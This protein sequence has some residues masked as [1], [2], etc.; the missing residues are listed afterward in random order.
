MPGR[1]GVT[2]AQGFGSLLRQYRQRA[3]LTQEELAARTGISTRTIRRL[4]ADQLRRPRSAT[5]RALADQLG[6]DPAE[7]ATLMK[8]PQPRPAGAIPAQLPMDAYGFTGRQAH[9][10]TLDA[11]VTTVDEQPTALLI[12]AIGGTAGIGKTALAV[13]W[14]HRVASRFPDG[15]LYV[16]MRAFAPTGVPVAPH[17]AVRGFLE[18]LGVPPA[19]IP[20]GPDAQVALYRSRLAGRRVL[21]VLDNVRDAD[22]V[23]PL[24][25]GA[26]GCA[27][28]VTSRYQ[29]TSLVAAEGAHPVDLD[30]LS[31]DEA[32]R[33]L[34]RRIGPVRAAAE[35]EAVDALVA[36]CC[37]LP[38]ALTIVAA[39]AVIQPGL[40]LAA[41]AVEL[42]G[43]RDDGLDALTAGD[44]TTD[45][46]AV[47]SWSY[48]AVPPAAGRLFRLLGLHRAPDL[49]VDAA[50]ALAGREPAEVRPLLTELARAHLVSEH[51]PG[52]FTFHDL[53]R[54]YAGELARRADLEDERRAAGHRLLDHYLHTAVATGR[55]LA[56]GDAEGALA[57]FATEHAALLA[58]VDQAAASGRDAQTVELAQALYSFLELRGHWHDLI[59]VQQAAV[60]AARRLGDPALESRA[61][62]NVAAAGIRLG[63]YDEARSHLREAIELAARAGDVG[64]E[65]GARYNLAFLLDAQRDYSAALGE[66]EQ[67]MALYE[68]AG[69]RRGQSRA[70]AAVG[71][72]RAQLGEHRAAL[73]TCRQAMALF[74][75]LDDRAGLAGNLDTMGLAHLHL[76]EHAEALDCYRRAI[77]I[78]RSL[79][80]RHFEGTELTHLGDTHLALGDRDA[81][82]EAWSAGLTIL[83][84]LQHPDAADVRRRLADL[85]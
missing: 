67:A 54:A 79:G 14:A 60:E 2:P 74:E 42:A 71:W 72:Y 25:P 76:G 53:L 64:A 36:A 59:R 80:N 8:V 22:Q 35:P 26:P 33:L 82:R 84:E 43:A 41:L 27:V 28:V 85:D 61:H 13:H 69:N 20:A 1:V 50:A 17:E 10:D 55:L 11:L 15:Q 77:E 44:A 57:W 65:A 19:R 46:R 68:V 24:L 18:A 6:L 38:L 70:L 45:V 83:D 32:R 51:V 9:L 5:V 63:R 78:S 62:R 47:F 37:G 30:V 40:S 56:S 66:N 21:V 7:Q 31:P 75:E 48:R 49:G 23:R 4:E 34:V 16:N 12:S 81:A 29:L 73:V 52:R 39:R 3:L 58:A